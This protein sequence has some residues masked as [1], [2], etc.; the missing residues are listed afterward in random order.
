M[1]LY[2][3]L[4]VKIGDIAH[5]HPDAGDVMVYRHQR[6]ETNMHIFEVTCAGTPGVTVFARSY[7]EAARIYVAHRTSRDSDVLPD[8]EVKQRNTYWPGMDRQ[9]LAEALAF[10]ISGIGRLHPDRGWLILP[11]GQAKEDE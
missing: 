9:A 8:F 4:T 5:P 11:P 2:E 7:D 6:R 1:A 3:R 10:G